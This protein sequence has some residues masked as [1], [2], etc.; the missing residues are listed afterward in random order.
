MGATVT[1][2]LARGAVS[3]L[4]V[5]P[6]ANGTPATG[7][8]YYGNVGRYSIGVTTTCEP[9]DLPVLV[10]GAFGAREGDRGSTL[11][12]IPIGLSEPAAGVVTV[13]YQTVSTTGIG[14]ATAGVDYAPTAG[15]V[16]FRPGETSA[17]VPVRVFGDTVAET[18]L[19]LGEWFFV[20]FYGA[21]ANA[22]L[23]VSTFFGLGIGIIGDDD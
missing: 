12:R 5:S 18:P 1:S 13:R 16:T 20:Q 17:S 3:T 2:A 8:S 4:T 15:Q 10:P 19:Y 22:R 9:S 23:D 7:W 6:L 11:F 21:S 14:H